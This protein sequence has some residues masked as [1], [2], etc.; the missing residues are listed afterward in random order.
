MSK[1]RSKKSEI[2]IAYYRKG[3]LMSKIEFTLQIAHFVELDKIFS[4]S[5]GSSQMKFLNLV[6]SKAEQ[7]HR[8]WSKDSSCTLQNRQSVIHCRHIVICKS[9]LLQL[10]IWTKAFLE[11]LG[12]NTFEWGFSLVH[13]CCTMYLVWDNSFLLLFQLWNQA[14][15]EHSPSE[16]EEYTLASIVSFWNDDAVLLLCAVE[17]LVSLKSCRECGSYKF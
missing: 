2:N 9:F 1:V 16:R 15:K 10:W 12:I 5:F 14:S 13:E 17:E 6:F 8:M 11:K 7:V 4:K 3:W